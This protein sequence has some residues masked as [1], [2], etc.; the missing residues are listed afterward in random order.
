M[1]RLIEVYRNLRCCYCRKSVGSVLSGMN[2]GSDHRPMCER[3]Y[4]K[5]G[6]DC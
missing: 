2:M 1:R 4:E 5:G 3:C 6:D